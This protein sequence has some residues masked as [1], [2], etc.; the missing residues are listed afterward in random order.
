MSDTTTAPRL[1]GICTLI[2][3]FDMHESVAFYCDRLGF[4]LKQRSPQ[5]GWAWLER[6]DDDIELM[7]NTAW[8]DDERPATRP[9]D[10]VASHRDV[11]LYFRCEDVAGAVAILRA[12][13]LDVPDPRVAWYG[14]KQLAFKDPDGYGICLQWRV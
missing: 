2:Q 10:W 6:E 7:L 4:T 8:E 5:F 3:V 14:M 9:P 12:G 13:G 1:T 11:T